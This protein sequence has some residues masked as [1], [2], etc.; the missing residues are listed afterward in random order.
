MRKSELREII[1]EEISQMR[2]VT[3]TRNG[4][5]IYDFILPG[6]NWRAAVKHAERTDWS[7]EESYTGNITGKIEFIQRVNGVDVIHDKGAGVFIFVKAGW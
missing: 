5:T 2:E 1:R 6:K 4:R 7:R 3:L